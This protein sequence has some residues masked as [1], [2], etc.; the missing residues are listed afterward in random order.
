METRQLSMHVLRLAYATLFLIAVIAVF[1]LWSQV[2]GQAH[3]DLVPWYLKLVLG[4]GAAFAFVKAAAAAASHETA[5]NGR[6]LRWSGIFLVLLLGCGLASYY[7]HLY[8]EDED[9]GDEEEPNV[10]ALVDQPT[11]VEVYEIPGIRGSGVPGA[12]ADLRR[13][14]SARRRY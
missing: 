5:W 10:S 13:I 14:G 8:Y 7:A 3:L 11:I 1:V 9:D 2:G 4:S 12:R 6:C